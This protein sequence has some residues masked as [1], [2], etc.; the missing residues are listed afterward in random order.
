MNGYFVIMPDL[1]YGDAVPL[2][3][4]GEFD[5]QKWRNGGYHLDVKSHLPSTVDPI[6]ESCLREM[7]TKFNCK[8]CIFRVKYNEHQ[9]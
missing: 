7:R 3:K 1:F 8:V 4:P 9:Y 5:M 2:N 6:V